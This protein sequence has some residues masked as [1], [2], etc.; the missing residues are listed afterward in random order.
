MNREDGKFQQLFER[1][2]LK[3][4]KSDEQRGFPVVN[5]RQLLPLKMYALQLKS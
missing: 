4:V 5:K 1:A 2:G 3:L